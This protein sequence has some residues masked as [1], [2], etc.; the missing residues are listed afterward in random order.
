MFLRLIASENVVM[1]LQQHSHELRAHLRPLLLWD[2][3]KQ[4][5]KRF[6]NTQGRRQLTGAGINADADTSG[7]AD[8]SGDGRCNWFIQGEIHGL[9]EEPAAEVLK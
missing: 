7:A 9:V 3:P 1:L 4:K 2:T 5:W 8:T 6:T